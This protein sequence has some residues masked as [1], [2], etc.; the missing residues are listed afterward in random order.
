MV[1]WNFSPE[2][3]FILEDGAP[4]YDN[5][6]R[7]VRHH[8]S[9]RSTGPA[10]EAA[11]QAVVGLCND[12]AVRAD[13][14]ADRAYD[15]ALVATYGYPIGH[16]AL[17]A[18]TLPHAERDPTTLPILTWVAAYRTALP[19]APRR[20]QQQQRQ[21]GQGNGGGRRGR[22]GGGQA[23]TATTAAAPAAVSPQRATSR[24]RLY[25]QS[26]T[27]KRTS[28]TGVPSSTSMSRRS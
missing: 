4:P 28:N 24:S 5:Y 19:P 13:W 8:D 16:A 18:R 14:I 10:R 12:A 22:R 2:Q 25:S 21:Q 15:A 7:W 6:V 1:L 27:L 20:Q 9:L 26:P 17:L 23:P 3:G 11:S